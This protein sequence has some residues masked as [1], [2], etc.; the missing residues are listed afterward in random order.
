MRTGDDMST[1]PILQLPIAARNH[2]DF[3]R[4]GDRERLAGQVRPWNQPLMAARTSL[5]SAI[6]RLGRG[7]QG[8]AIP[9]PARQTI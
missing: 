3:I 1:D 5:G 2:T 7:V 8:A 4:D 6:I 9:T